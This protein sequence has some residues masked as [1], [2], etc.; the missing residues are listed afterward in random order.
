[1]IFIAYSSMYYTDALWSI[2]ITQDLLYGTLMV[3][4]MLFSPGNILYNKSEKKSQQDFQNP[5]R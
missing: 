2:T 5:T 1:M 4:L 3:V